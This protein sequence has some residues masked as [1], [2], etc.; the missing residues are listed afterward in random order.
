VL[1]QLV[2]VVDQVVLI[3]YLQRSLLLEAEAEDLKLIQ[4]KVLME[5]QA[6]AEPIFQEQVVQELQIKVL[7]EAQVVEFTEMV[8]EA[9]AQERLV[10]Y[11][12]LQQLVDLVETA[13][14]L[15]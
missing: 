3:A 8:A 2:L 5:D 7:L 14:L 4:K 10:L 12:M 6:E 15:L 1:V 11:Q 9:E 13:L